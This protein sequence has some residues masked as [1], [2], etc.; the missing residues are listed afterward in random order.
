MSSSMPPS[1]SQAA[2]APAAS[3][4]YTAEASTPPKTPARKGS[5]SS[6]IPTRLQPNA[7]RHAGR[8]LV[9]L[10]KANGLAAGDVGGLS[11]P[12]VKLELRPLPGL[13]Q[14]QKQ[15][16]QTFQQVSSVKQETLNP[17]YEESFVFPIQ[18]VGDCYLHCEVFDKDTVLK[19]DFLGQTEVPLDMV[20]MAAKPVL[21]NYPLVKPPNYQEPSVPIVKG[22]LEMT[23]CYQS[24]DDTP[25]VKMKVHDCAEVMEKS[26]E[27]C[28]LSV[29]LGS[30]LSLYNPRLT[31]TSLKSA[32]NGY[33][34]WGDVISLDVD[35]T[36]REKEI[37]TIEV[38]KHKPKLMSSKTKPG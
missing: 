28:K 10:H 16:F 5:S 26:G 4:S 29:R 37:V 25:Y 2:G 9:T 36:R 31:E 35:P 19:N 1:S 8:L 27:K 13:N 12:F 11:D 15:Q 33:C 7:K 17:V 21:A 38:V 18:T 20:K 3:T 6:S 22:D 14:K 34:L 30:N 32:V 23:L 24:L